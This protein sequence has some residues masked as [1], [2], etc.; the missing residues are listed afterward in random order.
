LNPYES[1]A[2]APAIGHSWKIL[3]H[4]VLAQKLPQRGEIIAEITLITDWL[5][6]YYWLSSTLPL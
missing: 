1:H 4:W 5:D 2:S 3:L 6:P